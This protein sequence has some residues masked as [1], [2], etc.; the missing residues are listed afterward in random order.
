MTKEWYREQ[1]ELRGGIP[2]TTEMDK[3]I[4]LCEITGLPHEVVELYGRPQVYFPNKEAPISDAICH[5]MSCGHEKGLIEILGLA[6]AIE[7]S[8][9]GHL[10]A[11]E[12]FCRWYTYWKKNLQ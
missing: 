6:K 1:E 9:E 5:Y 2:E 8:V 11:A 10:T 7:G 3:L 12:V 4:S